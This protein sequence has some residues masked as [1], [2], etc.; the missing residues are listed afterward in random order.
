M[1]GLCEWGWVHYFPATFFSRVSGQICKFY[2]DLCNG[3]VNG[4]FHFFLEKW[5]NTQCSRIEK[6]MENG[7]M[8]FLNYSCRVVCLNFGHPGLPAS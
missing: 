5:N 1:N 8:L 2:I 6:P 4:K 7:S 3:M